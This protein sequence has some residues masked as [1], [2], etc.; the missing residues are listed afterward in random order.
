MSVERDA[1]RRL[2]APDAGPR[3]R[4]RRRRATAVRELVERGAHPPLAVVDDLGECVRR[5]ERA[6]DRGHPVD[7]EPIR[8]ALRVEV[9]SPLDRRTGRRRRSAPPCR[10]RAATAAIRRPSSSISVASGGIEPGAI[11][12]TSAWCARFATQPTSSGPTK[13]GATTVMSL[14]CVPPANGS[15]TTNSSPGMTAPLASLPAT[16]SITAATDAG[17]E[18]RCTGMCSACASSSPPAVNTAAEQSA[19]S[20]MLGLYAARRSTAPISSAIPPSREIRI[21]S[22][23]GSRLTCPPGES[24]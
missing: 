1:G 12:P 15:F 20:L 14:R 6:D 13:H 8:A 22:D 23:A 10:G 17:I 18:P 4:A 3:S 5:S 24:H 2:L 21:W 16:A 7:A 9:A 11:P 19:R